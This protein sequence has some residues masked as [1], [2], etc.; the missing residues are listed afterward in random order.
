MK[1][2]ILPH[3]NQ[4]PFW[5][6]LGI[7]IG[8]DI[9]I[10]FIVALLMGNLRQITNLFFLSSIILFVI[11]V[12]PIATEIG[13]SAKIVGKSLRESQRIGTQLKDKKSEF[14]RGARTTY[15]FG[16]AGLIT[17]LLSILTIAFG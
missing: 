11:A 7:I 13:S 16:L 4:R 2:L 17:F 9:L 1:K 3:Q 12:I 14:D 10:V 6:R 8:I 5:Q 15:L